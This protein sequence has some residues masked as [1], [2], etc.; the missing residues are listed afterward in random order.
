MCKV[1]KSNGNKSREREDRGVSGHVLRAL[2][3]SDA[4]FVIGGVILRLLLLRLLL[5]N[6]SHTKAS[7]KSDK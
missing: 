5:R 2:S 1:E 7:S 3:I 6:S 4:I